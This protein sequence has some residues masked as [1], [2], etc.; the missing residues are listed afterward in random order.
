MLFYKI[1]GCRR[2][3]C[4]GKAVRQL[5][6][7]GKGFGVRLVKVYIRRFRQLET[8][9]KTVKTGVYHKREGKVRIGGR[10]AGILTSCERFSLDHDT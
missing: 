1:T 4:R 9:L 3:F 7:G 6:E 10:I 5:S 8:V 2:R